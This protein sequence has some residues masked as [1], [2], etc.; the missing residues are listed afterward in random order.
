M[1]AGA[2]WLLAAGAAGARADEDGWGVLLVSSSPPGAYVLLDG[3]L[4]GRTPL[5]A[6]RVPTGEHRIWLRSRPLDEFEPLPI[7]E[8]RFTVAA[9][10]S[11]FVAERL[12]NLVRIE[13]EPEGAAIVSGDQQ[14][15]RTP[16]VLRW[17]EREAEAVRIRYPGYF[18]VELGSARLATEDLIQVRLEAIDGTRGEPI[19]T[20]GR[21]PLPSWRGWGAAALGAGFTVLALQLKSEADDSYERY[22]ASAMPSEME[23]HLRRADRYDRYATVS[24][25]AAEGSFLLALWFFTENVLHAKLSWSPFGTV[26]ERGAVMGAQCRF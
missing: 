6:V 2:A 19:V 16:S 3:D 15:G 26:S 7:P 25:I 11:V 24:W 13:S 1:T 21:D 22:L 5:D 17:C 18:S 4:I 9:G 12:G 20:E 23:R 10:E 14:L 8:R